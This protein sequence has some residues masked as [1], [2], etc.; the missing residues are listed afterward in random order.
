MPPQMDADSCK[1]EGNAAMAEQDYVNAMKWYSQAIALSP[2]DG[3]LFSNRSFAFLR[4]GLTSRALA[5][6]DEAVRRRP[7]W[8]KGHFRRAECL[9]QAGLHAEAHA[10]YATAARLDPADAHVQKACVEAQARHASQQ[11]TERLYAVVG[12]LAGVV[13]FALLVLAPPTPVEGKRAPPPPG[14]ATKAVALLLGAGLGALAAVGGVALQRHSRKGKTLPPLDTNERFA[15]MQM[16]GDVGGAG[17]L[18]STV[19]DAPPPAAAA[20]AAA[21]PATP[22]G[23]VPSAGGSGGGSASKGRVKSTANGRAAALKAMGKGK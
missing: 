18:R 22:T 20:T 15:A 7:E 12:A 23:N 16:R 21:A 9:K 1:T 3:A 8:N 6:A 14:L 2:R 5:D 4:L 17:E 19:L 11:R 10:A 13:L